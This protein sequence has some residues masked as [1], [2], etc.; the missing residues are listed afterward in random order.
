VT[1]EELAD[2]GVAS[3]EEASEKFGCGT[4]CGTCRPYIT[5]MLL[6]GETAFSI[7]TDLPKAA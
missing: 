7:D 2:A 3:L 4:K 6:T 1:F 5:K